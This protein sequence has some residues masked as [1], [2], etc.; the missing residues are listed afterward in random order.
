MGVK[1]VLQMKT[2]QSRRW[3]IRH[4]WPFLAE[5]FHGPLLLDRQQSRVK[6]GLTC[7][8]PKAASCQTCVTSFRALAASLA[9]DRARRDRVP[10]RALTEAS[11]AGEETG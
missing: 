7:P 9:Q 1:C 10:E 5:G 2:S 6:D 3:K 11:R 8:V 4:S